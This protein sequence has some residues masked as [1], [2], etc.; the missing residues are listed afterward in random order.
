MNNTTE[1]GYEILPAF[2]AGI[3]IWKT[4]PPILIV[5]GTCGNVLSIVVLTAKSIRGST[6][7]LYLL[8]LTVS[9]L[10][11][12][13]TGLLRQ[14]IIYL[15]EFDVRQVSEIACKIHTW[16]VYTSV[17]FSAWLLIAVTLE[18]IIAV[19]CPYVLKRKCGRQNGSMLI[20]V[21]LISLLGLNSHFLY[22]MVYIRSPGG[23]DKCGYIDENYQTFMD[24]AWSWIDLCAFC[25]IPL[26][27]IVVGNCL[28]LLKVADSRHKTRRK[29]ITSKYNTSIK[30]KDRQ[31]SSMTAILI[32]LNTVFLLTTLPISIYNIG[33]VHWSTTDDPKVLARLELWWAVVNMFMYTNNAVN[34]VLYSLSGSQFREEAK[35][36]FCITKYLVNDINPKKVMP[37]KQQNKNDTRTNAHESANPN[38]KLIVDKQDG[39]I[40]GS[41][42]VETLVHLNNDYDLDS[43]S[44]IA[45]KHD[46]FMSEDGLAE[47][48]LNEEIETFAPIAEIQESNRVSYIEEI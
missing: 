30:N 11:V 23:M 9:D 47:S 46:S 35:R 22:G 10:A 44:Q 42:K 48:K 24:K 37:T 8:I 18:R 3:L 36:I 34:F 1:S 33:H 40:N 29:Y 45:L 19:W 43:R 32:T 7:G 28:I 15:F 5:F 31:Q 13:Y 17:D 2:K 27:F 6:T 16:L 14:W 25:L 20:T 26:S 21:I 4:I 12:L 38:S 41:A 39:N